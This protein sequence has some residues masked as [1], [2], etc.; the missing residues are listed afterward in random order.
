MGYTTKNN[1]I[2]FVHVCP[3]EYHPKPKLAYKP[4]LG[5]RNFD[6]FYSL[7]DPRDGQPSAGWASSPCRRTVWVISLQM[8]AWLCRR[9][10]VRASVRNRAIRWGNTGEF[11]VVKSNRLRWNARESRILQFGWRFR[12]KTPQ[13]G[14]FSTS[15]AQ[16]NS[17]SF[18]VNG[19]CSDRL[20]WVFVIKVVN[21]PFL[22]K[23]HHESMSILG[24]NSIHQMGFH[25]HFPY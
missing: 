10:A 2:G 5:Y 4:K 21:W 1:M 15:F 22:Q 3:Q 20:T 14:W 19:P 25:H 16:W 12:G 6:S 17:N 7:G 13:I 24:F 11:I 8:M 18:R 9:I 23:K